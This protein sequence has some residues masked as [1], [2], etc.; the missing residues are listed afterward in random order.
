[1]KKILIYIATF[2]NIGLFPLAPGTL[3]SMVTM[4]LFY[5]FNLWLFPTIYSQVFIIL[6]VFIIGIPAASVAEKHFKRKD[7]GQVVIDEVPGQMISLLFLPCSFT[8]YSI[9]H[10]FAGFLLFRIFDII[11][12]F[13]V[14]KADN[15]PGGFGIMFDDIVAGLYALGTLQLLMYIF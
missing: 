9:L 4:I 5:L 8:P 15:I 3:A 7:P 2:F 12:P 6:L 13:P 10:Y 11:K 14:N 1:M